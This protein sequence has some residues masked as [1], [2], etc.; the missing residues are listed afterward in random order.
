MISLAIVGGVVVHVA[1]VVAVVVVVVVVVLVVVDVPRG[2]P[3][4]GR[5]YLSKT[6]HWAVLLK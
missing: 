2:L 4:T 6:D 5:F 3:N 1:V